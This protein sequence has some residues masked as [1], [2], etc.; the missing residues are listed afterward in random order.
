MAVAGPEMRPAVDL[1]GGRRSLARAEAAAIARP[2]AAPAAKSTA[3]AIAP[4]TWRSQVRFG[5]YT[6]VAAIRP[7]FDAPSLGEP[8]GEDPIRSLEPIV[9]VRWAARLARASHAMPGW[10]RRL[11]VL[12]LLAA[13]AWVG[14]SRI[15]HSQAAHRSQDEFWARIGQRAA[16][17]IQDDFRSG[18]S[19]WTGAPDWARSWSYDGTGFARPGRLALLSGSLPLDDYRLEFTAQIERKA[20]AWVFRAAD[21]NNYYATK[22]VESKRGVAPVFSIVR[23]AV[24]EGRERLKAELPLPVTPSAR[25]LLHV[26]QEIRGAQFTTYLDGGIVDT[27]SD[28]SLARGGVGFF[29]DPGEA[30]YIRSIAVAQNDDTIGRLCSYLASLRGK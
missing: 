25:T 27:W 8:G 19:Q 1:A 21:R 6:R 18:L 15:R 9:H 4:L 16:I 7:N 20:V 28:A 3:A 30:A 10:S 17:E 2:R 22:L 29:A 23:Y 5:P 26:R 14:A 11:A 24:I 13:M 12:M